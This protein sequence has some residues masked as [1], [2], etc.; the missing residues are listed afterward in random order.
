MRH[1][2]FATFQFTR[3]PPLRTGAKIAL[4]LR[5]LNNTPI[6]ICGIIKVDVLEDVVVEAAAKMVEHMF[7]AGIDA[8]HIQQDVRLSHLFL[9]GRDKE[10]RTCET[11]RL[12]EERGVIEYRL[13]IVEHGCDTIRQTGERLLRAATK[14]KPE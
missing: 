13:G 3:P 1:I 12:D 2:W 4:K 14:K 6:L 11:F 10:H 5:K 7:L 8:A 9:S